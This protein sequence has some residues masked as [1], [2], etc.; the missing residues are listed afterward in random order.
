MAESDTHP[1]Q[2]AAAADRLRL[3][4]AV[5]TEAGIVTQLST[6]LL[7]TRLPKGMVAAQFS[8]LNHLACRPAG[9]T[10][11]RIARAFQVP[12]TSMTH[13]LAVLER[14]GLVETAPNPEDGRSKIVRITPAG[15]DFR[16]G[17]IA[18][19]APDMARNLAALDPGTLERLLPL[20]THLRETLDTARD[21]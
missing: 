1:A 20:L 15:Q 2:T 11:L 18:A 4:F 13:S 6:A 3:A 7:E 10:P 21:R 8:V 17:V 12:K 19:L 16:A 9:Q 14:D 5:L